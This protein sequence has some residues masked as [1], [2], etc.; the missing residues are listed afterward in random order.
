MATATTV[1]EFTVEKTVKLGSL[2]IVGGA[3]AAGALHATVNE[4]GRLAERGFN[5]LVEE[6]ARTNEGVLEDTQWGKEARTYGHEVA[7]GTVQAGGRGYVSEEHAEQFVDAATKRAV[8]AG[9]SVKST[10]TA[11]ATTAAAR[12]SAI[13]R[14]ASVVGTAASQHAAALHEGVKEGGRRTAAAAT[15]VGERAGAFGRSVGSAVGGFRSRWFGSASASLSASASGGAAGGSSSSS[16]SVQAAAAAAKRN[17][18]V[19]K[20]DVP[21][22]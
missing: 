12:A 17:R 19:K 6:P 3:V 5:Q 9:V 14:K 13:R 10:A 21:E 7:V 8:G 11:G 15:A 18:E 20:R 4:A 1:T 16:S 22:L 2:G